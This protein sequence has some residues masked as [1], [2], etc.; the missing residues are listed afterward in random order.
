MT[1]SPLQVGPISPIKSGPYS[2]KF[3]PQAP[4][5]SAWT[6]LSHEL[7]SLMS[8]PIYPR[9]SLRGAR[10]SCRA[11]PRCQSTTGGRPHHHQ[12]PTGLNR[13]VVARSPSNVPF[14]VSL[15]NGFPSSSR[16]H[17]VKPCHGSCIVARAW[18][19]PSWRPW[20]PPS[21]ISPALLS[22][23]RSRGHRPISS[24]R[25]RLDLGVPLRLL[26]SRPWIQSPMATV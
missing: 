19:H 1:L 24:R 10:Q 6:H 18:A 7:D 5:P 26:K 12:A 3:V 15:Q 8:K 9:R 16:S 4:N 2:S 21:S 11:A 17:R 23:R 25:S 13:A 20:R 22:W 14:T